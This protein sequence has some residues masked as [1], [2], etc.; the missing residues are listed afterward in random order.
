VVW[1]LVADE[2]KAFGL[3]LVLSIAGTA[4]T[5]TAAVLLRGRLNGLEFGRVAVRGLWFLGAA[6]VAGAVGAG[7]VAL[8]GG[9]GD[10]AFPVSGPAG[11]IATMALAG[12]SMGLVYFAI[13]WLTRNPEL[14]TFIT[15]IAARLRGR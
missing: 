2:W 15:P 5:L 11:G 6:V 10:G 12:A 7:V 1:N 4:Q 13:L 3:A 9:I 14:R 8:L